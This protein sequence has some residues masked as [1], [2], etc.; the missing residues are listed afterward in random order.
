MVLVRVWV[1]VAPRST[2]DLLA[3]VRL[4][5][6][7]EKFWARAGPQAVCWLGPSPRSCM[8]YPYRFAWSMPTVLRNWTQDLGC[9]DRTVVPV[10]R[11]SVDFASTENTSPTYS[12][13]VPSV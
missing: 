11:C 4:R 13:C 12:R 2:E 7:P 8:V 6:F 9:Q 10:M 3:F 1:A 5:A